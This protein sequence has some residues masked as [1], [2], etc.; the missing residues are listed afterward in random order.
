MHLLLHGPAS[1]RLLNETKQAA[2]A[3][4][5]CSAMILSSLQKRRFTSGKE[6]SL[7]IVSEFTLRMNRRTSGR[8]H[9][10]L[11][12]RIVSHEGTRPIS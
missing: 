12:P 6:M 4:I 9:V 7:P 8:E 3:F 11:L 2:L 1:A 10:S 5:F